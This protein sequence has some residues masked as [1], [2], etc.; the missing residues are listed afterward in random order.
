MGNPTRIYLS[1]WGRPSADLFLL[2]SAAA[3]TPRVSSPVS[4]RCLLQVCR[5]QTD[6]QPAVHY[7]LPT[8]I[9]EAPRRP[10]SR[11]STAAAKLPTLLCQYT[12]LGPPEG[13]LLLVSHPLPSRRRRPSLPGF[14]CSK[15]VLWPRPLRFCFCS[16]LVRGTAWGPPTRGGLPGDCL[17]SRLCFLARIQRCLAWRF[18]WATTR[19]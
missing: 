2:C 16:L 10:L 5:L 4:P 6:T 8:G 13:T 14:C 3:A 9:S 11:P 19:R 1:L 18:S 17:A 15:R 7:P 12:P